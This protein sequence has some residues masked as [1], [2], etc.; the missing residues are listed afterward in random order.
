VDLLESSQ[1][2]PGEQ[3]DPDTGTT[4][5]SK[6]AVSE[7]AACN[8]DC[9]L[10]RCGDGYQNALAGEACDDEFVA[11][12]TKPSTEECDSDCTLPACGDGFM[13]DE[14]PIRL[15][16]DNT[17][18]SAGEQCDPYTGTTGDAQRAVTDSEFCD[19][20][21]S[22]ARCGDGY[23]N[24]EAGETCEFTFRSAAQVPESRADCDSDCTAPQ[25][26][27][28][29]ANSV[30]GES[31]D[32]GNPDAP[33]TT[34]DPELAA[35]DSPN[36]DRDCTAPACGDGLTN[37]EAD[38]ECDDGNSNNADGCQNDCTLP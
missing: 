15:L 2:L 21:C 28:G 5:N 31:C 23:I 9:S 18:T 35:D 3:C 7:S 34:P 8:R 37:D 26:G 36:C 10:P 6:R 11:S 13:N 19:L 20:D 12:G 1:T 22:T 24:P 4:T 29:F 27:D 25:C 30:F 17:T 32:P 14:V 38:E 16:F 33:I